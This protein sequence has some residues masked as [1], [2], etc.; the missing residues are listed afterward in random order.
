MTM[1]TL[2]FSVF[3]SATPSR[4]PMY[5]CIVQAFVQRIKK[6]LGSVWLGVNGGGQRKATN[7]RHTPGDSLE[8]K[9]IV[10]SSWFSTCFPIFLVD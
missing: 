10:E 1:A 2:F 4:I 7:E 5:C 8:G 6:E 9:H 3:Y